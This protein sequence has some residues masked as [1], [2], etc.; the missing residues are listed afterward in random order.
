MTRI[1]KRNFFFE[2]SH[3]KPSIYYKDFPKKNHF[4]KNDFV[5]KPHFMQKCFKP[6][7]LKNEGFHISKCVCHYCN[8]ICHF[9]SDCP[10]KINAHFE[11]KMIW[12]P[13]TNYEGPKIK[14]VPNTT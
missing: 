10:I 4:F 5:M 11:A 7:L 3:F 13:K 9:I 1:L 8:K 6:N 2:K 12:V 14:M